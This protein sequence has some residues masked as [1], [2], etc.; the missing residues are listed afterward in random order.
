V[1]RKSTGFSWN[2]DVKVLFDVIFSKNLVVLD[3]GWDNGLVMG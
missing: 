1:Q 2:A 3:M